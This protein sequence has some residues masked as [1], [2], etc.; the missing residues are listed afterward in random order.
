MDKA[1]LTT[2][3][4]SRAIIIGVTF[5]ALYFVGR[6]D[7]LVFH[8]LAEL[9]SIIVAAVIFILAWNTQRF[10][11]NGYLLFIGI[12]YFFIG[13]LDLFHTLAFKGMGVFPAY[14]AN[15][16]T[17]LWIAA[18]YLQGMSL[19]IAPIYLHRRVRTGL[20]LAVCTVVTA[21]ILL[22]IFRWGIFPA[23]YIEGSGITFF[24]AFSEGLISLIMLAAMGLLFVNRKAFDRNVFQLLVW[25]VAV[26]IA[27]ELVFTGYVAV[28]DFF[29]ML[30]HLLKI[31]A[32][33]LIYEA[34]VVT[35]LVKPFNLLFRDLKQNEAALSQARDELEIAVQQRTAEL[36]KTN[37][38][39]QQEIDVRRRA[40]AE[41]QKYREGLEELVEARTKALQHE[42]EV[43]QRAESQAR[44]YSIRLERSNREL[45]D[46]AS[47]TSHDLQE[48]LRKIR[49]FGDRLKANIEDSLGE[50]EAYYLERMQDAAARMQRMINDLLAYSRVTTRPQP[51]SQVDLGQIAQEVASDLE[52]RIEQSRGRVEFSDLPNIE[53]DPLQMRQLLQN[54]VSNALKFHRPDVP[55]VVHVYAS[56]SSSDGPAAAEAQIT[57]EDNGIGFDEAEVNHLFQPF[58][59]LVGRSEFEGSGMGL[60]ICQKI[61]RRHGG[62]ITAQSKPGQGTRFIVRLPVR[63]AEK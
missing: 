11:E 53:A 5:L 17:Q 32:F 30:G 25:S 52:V 44:E 8:T 37:E 49:A 46:F 26:S 4:Y 56:L 59:R 36:V 62:S 12:A 29:N 47:I 3:Q 54:L 13:F 27:T 48:P 50:E 1:F 51:F 42:V 45:Q 22:S 58:H 19:L 55:P 16:P 7:Y 28:D 23:S 9:F 38:A 61:V 60:A 43:R 10:L 21:L 18:R 34:I 57:V 41:L 24:K 33:Y 2:N 20:M 14:D 6:S 63:Q 39:L 15:L 31:L 40:Q 35:G